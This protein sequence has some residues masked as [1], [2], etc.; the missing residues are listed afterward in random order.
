MDLCLASGARRAAEPGTRYLCLDWAALDSLTALGAPARA[1]EDLVRD[2]RADELA[3]ASREAADAW[4]RDAEGDMTLL[5]GVSLGR[6]QRWMLWALA[7][8]PA[9]KAAEALAAAVAEEKPRRID[10][11]A[12]PETVLGAVTAAVAVSCGAR[13]RWT[14]GG[15]RGEDSIRW[16]PP[17]PTLTLARRWAYAAWNALAPRA[18]TGAVVAEPYPALEPLL[19]RLAQEPGGLSLTDAPGRRLLRVLAGSAR[20]LV[21]ARTPPAWSRSER[22]PLERM[23]ARWK[24]ARA[25]TAWRGR[26]AWRGVPLWDALAPALDGFFERDAEAL[27]WAA[28]RLDELWRRERPGLLVLPS[29]CPPFANLLA[30]L[31]ARHR[32]PSS[33]VMHGLPTDYAYPFEHWDCSHLLVWTEE[34]KRRYEQADP[35]PS[36]TILVAGNPAFDRLQAREVPQGPIRR[37]LALTQPVDKTSAVSRVSDVERHAVTLARALTALPGVEAR[38]RLHPSESAAHYRAVLDAHGLALPLEQGAPLAASLES[39]DLVVGPFSTVLL[40]ALVAGRPV[41]GVNLTRRSLAAPFDG[42]SGV[43]VLRDEEGLR[44]ALAEAVARPEALRESARRARPA[45]LAAFAGPVD[46]S[47]SSRVA[48]ELRR[49]ADMKKPHVSIIVQARMGSTRLPGKVLK[50][51]L[52][53]TLLAH[54]V[55]RLRRVRNADSVIIATTVEPADDA[56]VAECARLGVLCTRGSEDDVLDR[57]HA[58]AKT[59]KADVVVRCTSD[60]PVIDPELVEELIARFLAAG[61]RDYG[62]NAAID[63]TYP[64]G[65]DAEICTFAALE[66]AN[67]ESTSAFEREHVL[68]FLLVRPQRFKQLSLTH[69]EDL[70]RHRWTVDTPEDFELVKRIL[71]SLYPKDARFTWTDVLALLDAHPDWPLLNAHVKQKAE[72]PKAP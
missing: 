68:E 58:A 53:K 4:Y 30:G 54:M 28:L 64:R 56:I 49:I 48:E 32:V 21:E 55:E 7:V 34:Q 35:R 18:G 71:E 39:V 19:T 62:S 22:A 42:G 14:G 37:V 29:D 3:R 40:E 61:D 52:G 36:R 44:R 60:C 33:V 8:H 43:P 11:D 46:G 25:S 13:L 27:A 72:G 57:Y 1:W 26:F 9:Y 10:C 38:L 41:L 66:T 16:H 63:R 15:E 23:A 50:T 12:G 51:V 20:V 17:R 31:A 24:A 67:K 65:L 69:R 5:R 2:E 59:V 70:S 47:A 6:A 45:L